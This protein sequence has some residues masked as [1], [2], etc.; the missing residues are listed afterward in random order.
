MA[1]LVPS[2]VP[3]STTAAAAGNV[4]TGT[5]FSAGD[6]G[7]ATTGDTTATTAAGATG[8]QQDPAAGAAG[9]GGGAAA[10]GVRKRDG[11]GHR[12]V[13]RPAGSGRPV[14]AAV[15]RVQG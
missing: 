5:G 13:R 4:D 12:E 1:L 11:R 3:D 10:A 6:G 7:G 2:K 15:H 8:A 9:G 14:L